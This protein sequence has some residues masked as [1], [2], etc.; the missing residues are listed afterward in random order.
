MIS[1]TYEA[2]LTLHFTQ[3][4]DLFT[5]LE[6][7]IKSAQRNQAKSEAKVEAYE[8]EVENLKAKLAA[9]EERMAEIEKTARVCMEKF[10]DL[11]KKASG[12]PLSQKV[13]NRSST[14]ETQLVQ[15]T[16]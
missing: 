7:D 15:L 2:I 6:V 16:H 10:Q 4:N 13:E 1:C 5:K 12:S 3:T 11:Q 8:K 9:S 14:V